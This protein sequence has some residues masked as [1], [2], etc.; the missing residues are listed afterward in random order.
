[1]RCM[2][3]LLFCKKLL[4]SAFSWSYNGQCTIVVQ[5][6]FL[7]TFLVCFVLVLTNPLKNIKNGVK[8]Q[9]KKTDYILPALVRIFV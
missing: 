8:C 4:D 6:D 7:R 2:S 5:W 9:W 1:M 3:G